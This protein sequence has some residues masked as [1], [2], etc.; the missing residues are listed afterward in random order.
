[1]SKCCVG[2]LDHFTLLVRQTRQ[3][4]RR[5]LLQRSD[6]R[7]IRLLTLWECFANH[8]ESKSESQCWSHEDFALRAYCATDMDNA[9][10]AANEGHMRVHKNRQPFCLNLEADMTTGIEPDPASDSKRETR[11]VGVCTIG[12]MCCTNAG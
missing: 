1:M 6:F 9:A 2:D 10:R 5:F 4:S 12:N 3:E 7:T 11:E 8:S